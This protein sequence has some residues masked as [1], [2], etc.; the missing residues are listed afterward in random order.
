MKKMIF[1]IITSML[2]LTSCSDNAEGK[3]E[4]T[5][6]VE[7]E[8]TDETE[9]EENVSEEEG[10]DNQEVDYIEDEQLEE[11]NKQLQQIADMFSE[12]ITGFPQLEEVKQGD[13]LATISTTHGDIKVKLLPEVAPKAVENFV[14]HANE[15]YY[16]NLVFHR[17][18]KDFMI[19]TGDPTATGMGGESIWG[20]PFEDEVKK[21]ARHFNGA[22]SMANSGPNT[23]GSQFFIIGSELDL[24]EMMDDYKTA[25]SEVVFV[26]PTTGEEFYLSDV[27]TDE[28]IDKYR[29]L[30]GSPH[31]DLNHTV[32]GQT[33]EGY[34]NVIEI[35]SV[36]VDES[37]KPVVDVVITGI[38]I[39]VVE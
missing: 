14:T 6:V 37:D 12:E 25:E 26:M 8:T 29:E 1:L 27:F 28:I 31:L 22:L 3:A 23:N 17:V 9:Q 21:S 20:E 32:F 39:T 36:E 34:E 30:G 4:Q 11:Y 35:A 33:I 19:Q 2:L 16:D 13:T 5:E 7:N 24:N 18:I 10:V 15:G 38:E